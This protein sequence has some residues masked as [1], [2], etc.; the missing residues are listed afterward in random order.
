VGKECGAAG[1][2]ISRSSKGIHNLRTVI[3]PGVI[4]EI[5]VSVA[6]NA[7]HLL[8]QGKWKKKAETE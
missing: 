5:E 6:V 2:N 3:I 1:F 4:H 8:S 7:L